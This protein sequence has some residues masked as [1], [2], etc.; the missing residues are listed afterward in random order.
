M[1][2]HQ[3]LAAGRWRKMPF[4]EQMSNIGSEIDRAL[5]WKAKNNSVYCQKAFDRALELLGLSLE[6][7]R[8]FPRLKELARV[9][10]TLADYFYG[11]NEYQSTES[12]WRN[13]FLHFTL[14]LR[15]D[16]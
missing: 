9:R 12:S 7:T 6:S 1:S 3:D 13:Y 14:A 4:L 16:H 15:K 8:E 10:E 2:V 11:S 5:H